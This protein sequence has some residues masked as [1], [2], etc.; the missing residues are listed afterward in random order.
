VLELLR[1]AKFTRIR[2]VVDRQ[3][4]YK[5]R[6]YSSVIVADRVASSWDYLKLCF[7]RVGI[8]LPYYRYEV[9]GY[10]RSNDIV[11]M[12]GKVILNIL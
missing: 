12:Q 5:D 10:I 1:V 6:G 11:F 9:I 3:K 2:D 7:W 8:W 4:L